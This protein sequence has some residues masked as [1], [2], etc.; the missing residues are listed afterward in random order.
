MVHIMIC[1]HDMPLH[2]YIRG[3]ELEAQSKAMK[4]KLAQAMRDKE[5]MKKQ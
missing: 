2:G 5:D 3:K 4:E 1:A